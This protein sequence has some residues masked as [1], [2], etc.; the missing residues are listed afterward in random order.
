MESSRWLFFFFIHLVMLALVA[1]LSEYDTIWTSLVS[2]VLRVMF[3][4]AGDMALILG[5]EGLHVPQLLKPRH[6]E[7]VLCDKRSHCSEKPVRSNEE[8][9]QIHI[10]IHI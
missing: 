4:N 6:P 2:P 1:V 9:A 5:P 3:A 10:H 7:P 8:S